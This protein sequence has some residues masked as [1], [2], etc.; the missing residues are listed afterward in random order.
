M[1]LRWGLRSLHLGEFCRKRRPWSNSFK[2]ENLFVSY[3][4]LCLEAVSSR[5][6]PFSSDFEG[7]LRFLFFGRV[8]VGVREG[9]IKNEDPGQIY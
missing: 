5:I 3:I 1:I 2:I 4:T 7:V 6:E 9:V 8:G